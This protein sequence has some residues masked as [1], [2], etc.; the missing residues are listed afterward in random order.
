MTD[1][2][3]LAAKA[4]IVDAG[5]VL[6]VQRAG[7]DVQEPGIWELP[8]GRLEL[9]EEPR[10]GLERE[11][12]EETGLSIEVG[13]PLTVRHFERDDGQTVTMI[14]FRCTTD[15]RGVTLSTEHQDAAWVPLEQAEDRLAGFFGREVRAYRSEKK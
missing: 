13:R 11:V 9:A 7:D 12:G 2:V 3:R 5:A 15:N 8:G 4:F 10:T 6:A 1:D 14:V